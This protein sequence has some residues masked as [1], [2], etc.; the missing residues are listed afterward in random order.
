M[1]TETDPMIV[2]TALYVKGVRQPGPEDFS[3]L[4]AI[5][6]KRKGF[7]WIGL[8]EPT[9]DELDNLAQELALH[10]LAVEDALKANQRPKMEIYDDIT[11]FTLKTI[12]YNPLHTLISTGEILCFLGEN[13]IVTVRHGEGSELKGLRVAMEKDPT[14]LAQG[15]FAVLHSIIDKVIDDS[16]RIATELEN[17]VSLLEKTIFSSEY[18]TRS[19]QI[20]TLKREVIEF[21]YLLEPLK[22]PLQELVAITNKKVKKELKPF[23]RD[24]QDHLIRACEHAETLDNILTIALQADLAHL[25]VQQNNDVRR[26]SAWVALA[27]GPTMVA[28]IYGMN[29]KYMPELSSKWGYPV[30]MSIMVILSLLLYKKFKASKWL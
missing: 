7:I 23:F 3:D 30:V 11:F 14:H 20:Y 8:K 18:K 24:T 19:Q 21:R 12:F 17:D 25:Q 22:I 27:A 16:V 9:M 15:P 26:I 6:K 10:P 28:G 2:N 29:F 5:A 4:L 13:Y 1:G